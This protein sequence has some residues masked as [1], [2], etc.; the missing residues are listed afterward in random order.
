MDK[1]RDRVA[2]LVPAGKDVHAQRA[3]LLFGVEAAEVTPEHREIGKLVNLIRLYT[4]SY[5]LSGG[6]SCR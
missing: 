2:F 3:A 5:M 4:P 6:T 1:S